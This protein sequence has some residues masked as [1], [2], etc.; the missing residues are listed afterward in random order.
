MSE[1]LIRQGPHKEG[2]SSLVAPSWIYEDPS[3]EL[4]AHGL[5]P[6]SLREIVED[7]NQRAQSNFHGRFNPKHNLFSVLPVIGMVI[8]FVICILDIVLHDSIQLMIVGISMFCLSAVL[9]M[10]ASFC[11]HRSYSRA[12]EY[13]MD[14]VLNHVEMRLNEDWQRC[15]GVRWF[16]APEQSISSKRLDLLNKGRISTKYNIGVSCGE[17]NARFSFIAIGRPPCAVSR[18]RSIRSQIR[19]KGKYMAVNDNDVIF[20]IDSDSEDNPSLGL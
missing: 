18:V 9:T 11:V 14:N 20:N 13:T 19:T 5:S 6:D 2:T 8:G 1:L 7:I 12:I 10:L 3:Q 17:Q 16:I 4:V 15:N